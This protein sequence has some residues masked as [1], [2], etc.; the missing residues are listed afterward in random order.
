LIW[1]TE[2]GLIWQRLLLGTFE[3]VKISSRFLANNYCDD[4]SNIAKLTM[5]D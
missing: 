2:N 4:L 5:I 1:Q 3:L